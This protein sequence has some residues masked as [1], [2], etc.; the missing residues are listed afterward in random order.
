MTRWQGVRWKCF[1]I[2]LPDEWPLFSVSRL[3]INPT[4]TALV[5]RAGSGYTSWLIWTSYRS[6]VVTSRFLSS[7]FQSHPSSWWMQWTNSDC[8]SRS[9]K[10][11]KNTCRVIRNKVLLQENNSYNWPTQNKRKGWHITLK[12]VDK[13]TLQMYVSSLG[14][15]LQLQGLESR[16]RQTLNLRFKLKI[17][18]IREWEDKNCPKYFLW[19][20]VTWNYFFYG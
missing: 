15:L 19:M 12:V 5:S 8:I 7:S 17:S 20:N 3:Q 9:T 18:Q 6:L 13:T 2:F 4:G 10:R 16:L 14:D 11:S 1:N